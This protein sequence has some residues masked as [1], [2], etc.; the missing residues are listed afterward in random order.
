MNW[1]QKL[2]YFDFLSVCFS[3]GGIYS[4][5]SV[6]SEIETWNSLFKCVQLYISLSFLLKHKSWIT[7]QNYPWQ[8]L[9]QT[10]AFIF[11][12]LLI[13]LNILS[14]LTAFARQF[15]E[16]IHF[17]ISK[18]VSLKNFILIRTLNCVC[19][20]WCKSSVLQNKKFQLLQ[21]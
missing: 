13:K 1:F 17:E 6:A 21:P 16:E 11:I 2:S 9:R 8:S 5:L 7:L 15:A 18:Q 4:F 20:T 10:D 12:R 19:M 14:R 3:Q